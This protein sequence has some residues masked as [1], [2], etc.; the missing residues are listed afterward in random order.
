MRRTGEDEAVN[1]W[2]NVGCELVKHSRG[3]PNV[4]DPIARSYELTHSDVWT[5]LEELPHRREALLKRHECS[6]ELGFEAFE[7]ELHALFTHAECAAIREAHERQD[8]DLPYVYLDGEKHR[9]VYRGE[10]TY[11]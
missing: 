4:S 2:N 5:V 7:Q 10:K 3:L 11:L 9:Q 8:V 1:L 6:R